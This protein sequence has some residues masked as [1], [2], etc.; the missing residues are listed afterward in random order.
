MK[1]HLGYLIANGL[2]ITVQV[3]GRPP[4]LPEITASE[5]VVPPGV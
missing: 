2:P 3:D 5:I 4:A 1:P